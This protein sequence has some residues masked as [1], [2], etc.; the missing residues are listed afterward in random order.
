MELHFE[1]AQNF[2]L[3]IFEEQDI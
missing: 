2:E 1:L 3:I